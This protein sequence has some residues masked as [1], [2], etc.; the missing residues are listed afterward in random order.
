MNC[1]PA[2]QK[3]YLRAT[4]KEQLRPAVVAQLV[5]HPAVNRKVIG[6]S[7]IDGASSMNDGKSLIR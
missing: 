5:E 3:S 4:D 6:S 2:L 7:P 1:N